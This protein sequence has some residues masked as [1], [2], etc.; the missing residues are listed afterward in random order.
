MIMMISTY[1]CKADGR[2]LEVRRSLGGESYLTPFTGI[3]KPEPR[4]QALVNVQPNMQNDIESTKASSGDAMRTQVSHAV[5][6][7]K[8]NL[9][10]QEHDPATKSEAQNSPA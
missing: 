4:S 7:A 8:A 3:L 2:C 10:A 6:F 5:D 9:K 1:E